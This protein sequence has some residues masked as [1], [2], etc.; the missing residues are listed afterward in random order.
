MVKIIAF[1]LLVSSARA[2]AQDAPAP[3]PS[4]ESAPPRALRRLAG[5]LGPV[6]HWYAQDRSAA[7][8]GAFTAEFGIRLFDW[9]SVD[10]WIGARGRLIHDD[11]VSAGWL[12]ALLSFPVHGRVCSSHLEFRPTISVGPLIGE[13]RVTLA[14]GTQAVGGFQVGL[15]VRLAWRAASDR[16]GGEM[17]I[18]FGLGTDMLVL[19]VSG[20]FEPTALLSVVPLSFEG[21]W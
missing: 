19:V 8:G 5:E 9:G 20:E 10:F 4:S 2:V 6:A 18:G 17:Y 13:E 12:S 7:I 15:D 16:A 21:R 14:E 1:V 3:E 11:A